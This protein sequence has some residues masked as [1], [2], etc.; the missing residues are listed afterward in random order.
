[1]IPTKDYYHFEGIIEQVD[2]G[3]GLLARLESVHSRIGRCK[4][5]QDL[6]NIVAEYIL[7]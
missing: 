5:H 6:M 2:E 4:T 7:H 3:D 1:M